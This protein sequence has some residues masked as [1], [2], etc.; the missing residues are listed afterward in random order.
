MH[1]VGYIIKAVLASIIALGILVS[2][3][4][5]VMTIS[6]RK[7]EQRIRLLF[8][9]DQYFDEL[10][11]SKFSYDIDRFCKKK[12][13]YLEKA[14]IS[15]Q[16]DPQVAFVNSFETI[17]KID[18]A[19]VIL[20]PFASI[21]FIDNNNIDISRIHYRPIIIGFGNKSNNAAFD[22]M[23]D[24]DTM[25]VYED[26]DLLLKKIKKTG[27]KVFAYSRDDFNSRY[28]TSDRIDE[29]LDKL[30]PKFDDIIDT[31]NVAYESEDTYL[32]GFDTIVSSGYRQFGTYLK[33]IKQKQKIVLPYYADYMTDKY[34]CIVP[35]ILWAV[36]YCFDNYNIQSGCQNVDM[37]YTIKY[38]K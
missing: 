2:S 37:K 7:A 28:V 14:I 30:K 26:I 9:T 6:R 27:K 23:F 35:D 20:S 5:A 18:T 8:V 11:Y 38:I 24:M 16:D 22:F 31:R 34:Y 21:L 15:V 12:N 29:F 36:R 10:V 13:Y 17:T 25:L 32:D 4:Y 33:N 1:S 19:A 3:V